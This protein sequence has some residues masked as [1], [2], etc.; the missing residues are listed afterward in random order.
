MTFLKRIVGAGALG[1]T[2]LLGSGLILSPAQA[3]YIVVLEEVGNDVVATGSGTLDLGGLT[4][5]ATSAARG[6]ITPNIGS[7]V[8]G[9]AI[10]ADL[11]IY[12]GVTGPGN[13]GSGGS[14][15]ADSGSG[16]I[17][18]IGSGGLTLF[19]PLGY[20]SGTFL[21]NS[22]TWLNETFSSLGAVP[23]TYIWTLGTGPNADSFTLIIAAI[24]EPASAA[25][26]GVALVGLL[27]AD[28]IRRVQPEA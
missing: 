24:P 22:S 23:G 14:T 3:A 13:F 9:P 21:S 20:D 26:L 11:E 27:L 15:L 16:A 1:V 8:P 10:L 17:V 25:L 12:G 7:I 4:F 2:L 6:I 5:L 18:G 19:V 28:T